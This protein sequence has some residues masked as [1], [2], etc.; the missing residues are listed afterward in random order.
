MLPNWQEVGSEFLKQSPYLVEES[1]GNELWKTARRIMDFPLYVFF[2]DGVDD[3]QLIK[4][5]G[6]ACLREGMLLC[7]LYM[8][9]IGNRFTMVSKNANCNIRLSESFSVAPF[10]KRFI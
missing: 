5:E 1:F 4:L 8:Y 2:L 9:D 3:V 10:A 7:I 6:N